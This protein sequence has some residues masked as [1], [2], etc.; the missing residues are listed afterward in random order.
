MPSILKRKKLQAST[1]RRSRAIGLPEAMNY[2]E[3][4]EPNMRLSRALLIVLVLHIVAV[5]GIIAFN[6]LKTRETMTTSPV[7][8]NALAAAPSANTAAATPAELIATAPNE[9]TQV[10]AP[11]ENKAAQNSAEHTQPVIKTSAV[12]D[13]GKVHTVVRGENPVTIARHLH[14]DYDALLELNQITDPRKLQI[15]QKLRIPAAA[16]T[17]KHKPE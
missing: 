15:G 10:A 4:A 14:V 8:A 5:A 16:T 11:A 3:M 7:E 2:E 12:A 1:A 17:A 9:V 13:S 6:T